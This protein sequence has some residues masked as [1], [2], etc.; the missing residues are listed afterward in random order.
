MPAVEAVAQEARQQSAD[1]RPVDIVVA[2]DRHLL[3]ADH[4]VRQTGRG[5]VHVGQHYGSGIRPP[6]AGLRNAST[7]SSSMPRPAIMRA[8]RSGSPWRC[9]IAAARASPA[10]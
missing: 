4:R 6:N 10:H 5:G 8:K 9:A 1:V 7:S 3:A 2:E